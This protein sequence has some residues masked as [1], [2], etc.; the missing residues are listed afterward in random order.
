MQLPWEQQHGRVSLG[1]PELL[2]HSTLPGREVVSALE[3]AQVGHW[4]EDILGAGT[5][6][7]QLCLK[8]VNIKNHQS[9]AD[10]QKL[11]TLWIFYGLFHRRH[12]L[13]FLGKMANIHPQNEWFSIVEVTHPHNAPV[14]PCWGLAGVGG[15]AEKLSG[16][17]KSRQTHWP[18]PVKCS[19]E[20]GVCP[21]SSCTVNS[22]SSF[23]NPWTPPCYRSL[24]WGSAC[25]KLIQQ[26]PG[27]IQHWEFWLVLGRPKREKADVDVACLW[28]S[29]GR[30]GE[31]G[32][33]PTALLLCCS[34]QSIL[35]YPLPHT[36]YELAGKSCPGWGGLVWKDVRKGK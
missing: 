6:I 11:E 5:C 32:L 21:L 10:P 3:M 25:R 7:E 31:L 23:L 24:W 28:M 20:A 18:L 29:G 35:E 26:C 33:H 19:L 15:E 30:G 12:K 14:R 9:G 4:G 27:W 36:R 8:T 22:S 34:Q 2:S 16:W 1:S 17:E 13:E